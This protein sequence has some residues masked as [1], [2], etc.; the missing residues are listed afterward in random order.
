MPPELTVQDGTGVYADTLVDALP[1]YIGE[2]GRTLRALAAQAN[3]RWCWSVSRAAGLCP[4]QLQSDSYGY[5][6]AV[7][8]NVTVRQ[9]VADGGDGGLPLGLGRGRPA[10]PA[11]RRRRD[12]RPS[13]RF[14]FPVRRRGDSGD[15]AKA[16]A[17]HGD[18]RRAGGRHRRR[19]FAARLSAGAGTAG[20]ADGGPLLTY[21]RRSG[22]YV[23]QPDRRSNRAMCSPVGRHGH[24]CGAGRAD[25]G[26]HGHDDA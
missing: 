9:F 18:L 5:I 12:R 23:H 11:D 21:Q 4:E 16:G 20:G 15:T 24:A 1:D 10:Q 14:H 6:S 19:R 3:C 2:A 26:S 8:P 25:A 7:R 22:R 13:R 17:G